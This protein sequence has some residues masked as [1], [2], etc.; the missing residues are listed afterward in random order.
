MD[1]AFLLQFSGCVVQQS[2]GFGIS[3][4][5]SLQDFDISRLHGTTVIWFRFIFQKPLKDFEVFWLRGA[6]IIW[7]RYINSKILEGFSQFA[8]AWYN[9]HMDSTHF[10]KIIQGFCSF[11]V[12]SAE[13]LCSD[14]RMQPSGIMLPMACMRRCARG[15]CEEQLQDGIGRSFGHECCDGMGVE[16]Q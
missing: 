10:P 9:S 16:K 2:Y 8:V 12:T 15:P 11:R 6:T 5:K 1:S 14:D 4:A 13:C 7:I 3:T